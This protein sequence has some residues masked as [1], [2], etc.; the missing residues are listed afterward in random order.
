MMNTLK[1]YKT[2]T[3]ADPHALGQIMSTNA[4]AAHGGFACTPFTPVHETFDRHTYELRLPAFLEPAESIRVEMMDSKGV[5]RFGGGRSKDKE[6]WKANLHL[7]YLQHP[8]LCDTGPAAGDTLLLVC[9]S[10]HCS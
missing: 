5:K 2:V 6:L 1:A 7:F 10:G 8:G 9:T 4:D 3:L